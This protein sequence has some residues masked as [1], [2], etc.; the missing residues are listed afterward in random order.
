MFFKKNLNMVK[1]QSKISLSFFEIST[2]MLYLFWG[3]AIT[4][5]VVWYCLWNPSQNS[6]LK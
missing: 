3:G 1:E 2:S 4:P 5:L 6:F